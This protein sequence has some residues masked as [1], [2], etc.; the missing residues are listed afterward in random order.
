[1]VEKRAFSLYYMTMSPLKRIQNVRQRPDEGFRVWYGNEYYDLIFWYEEED[2]FIQGFQFCYGKPHSEKAFTWELDSSSHHY[3]KDGRYNATGIL[4]GN[5]GDIRPQ[6]LEQFK[7]VQGE[8]P[9]SLL[10][11]VLKKLTKK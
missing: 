10:E 9:E 1:M 11:F 2:G 8:L 6:V 4:R 7:K 3:V 5:P